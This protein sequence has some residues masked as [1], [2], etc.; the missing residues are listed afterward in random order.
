MDFFCITIAL[1][2][3]EKDP[4]MLGVRLGYNLFVIGLHWVDHVFISYLPFLSF[5]P[6]RPINGGGPCYN[7]FHW[8]A[9]YLKLMALLQ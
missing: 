4:F 9:T 7:P 8:V 5:V 3:P 2:N 6:K 1:I